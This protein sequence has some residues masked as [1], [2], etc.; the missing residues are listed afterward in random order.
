M[1][2]WRENV[3]KEGNSLQKRANGHLNINPIRTSTHHCQKHNVRRHIERIRKSHKT[4]HNWPVYWA[5]I[6]RHTPN[7]YAWPTSSRKAS[8]IESKNAGN[9]STRV[10]IDARSRA[11]VSRA[12][13]AGPARY[14]WWKKRMA[15]GGRAETT[16]H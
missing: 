15:S 16:A 3:R 10:S 1:E 12:A 13:A 2:G 9:C 8:S 5:N 4:K 6:K 11:S 7:R 14:I